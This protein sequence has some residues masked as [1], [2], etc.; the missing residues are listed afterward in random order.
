MSTVENLIVIDTIT[1]I[2]KNSSDATIGIDQVAVNELRDD[3]GY[4]GV[5]R[6][7]SVASGITRVSE[8]AGE[9]RVVST[10]KQIGHYST[11]TEV[12]GNF[13]EVVYLGSGNLGDLTVD[14]TSL[15][16]IGASI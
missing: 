2:Y 4:G 13:T 9:S 14:L 11:F 15:T 7:G 1:R 3:D 5:T 6:T 8:G 12:G 16:S 10:I